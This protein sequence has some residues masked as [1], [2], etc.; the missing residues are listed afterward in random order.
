MRMSADV[1]GES[2]TKSRSWRS[3][4]LIELPAMRSVT[5][6]PW[7]TKSAMQ[8]M[9]VALGILIV[10]AVVSISWGG[11]CGSF[12]WRLRLVMRKLWFV[13]RRLRLVGRSLRLVLRNLRF[14][15]KRLRLVMKVK[16]LRG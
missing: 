14:V 1:K 9:I 4:G 10:S 6:R 7:L 3:M 13:L 11:D 15:L 2:T 12:L 5:L 16:R 8:G